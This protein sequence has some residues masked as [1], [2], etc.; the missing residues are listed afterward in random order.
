MPAKRLLFN[1][2]PWT[3]GHSSG[4][5]HGL[6][7]FTWLPAMKGQDSVSTSHIQCVRS[8]A[9]QALSTAE[10]VECMLMNKPSH[11]DPGLFLPGGRLF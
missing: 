10:V 7:V 1:V 8:N 6:L 9:V 4:Q 3:A 11:L 5:S 2:Q